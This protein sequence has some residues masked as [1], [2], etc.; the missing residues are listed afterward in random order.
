[1][2]PSKQW[3]FFG[4]SLIIAA[5]VQVIYDH[6]QHLSLFYPYLLGTWWG[7]FIITYELAH[8]LS[9]YINSMA[10]YF[11][12]AYLVIT[13]LTWLALPL[14]AMLFNLIFL[15]FIA[16]LM[17]YYTNAIRLKLHPCLYWLALLAI[18][19]SYPAVFS[20]QRGNIENILFM[21]I[22]VCLI[23]FQRKHYQWS[24]VLLAVA[25][26]MKLYPAVLLILF[27]KEKQY[28]ALLMCVGLTLLFSF[29]ALLSFQGSISANISHYYMNIQQFNEKNILYNLYFMVSLFF[30]VKM[31]LVEALHYSLFF[32]PPATY[33]LPTLFFLYIHK[34]I[35]FYTAAVFSAFIALAFYV[36]YKEPVFWKNVTLLICIMILFPTISHAYKMMH[37]LPA[38]LIFLNRDTFSRHVD[39]VYTCLFVLLF[40]PKI[41]PMI[42][43]LSNIILM[44]TLVLLIIGERFYTSV[45]LR[46]R[47]S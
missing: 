37:L 18:F 45:A 7:D 13:P 23:Q 4:L 14:S 6:A 35:P 2:N 28:K 10:M 5:V 33:E 1:M 17:Q 8:S 9:P 29:L 19:V 31:M 43:A 12:L 32:H 38:F 21:I 47:L 41:T 44:L 30:L 34:I 27:F 42:S 16:W 15:S 22:A 25:I 3:L 26:G 40:I 36:V 24:A 39:K 46:R 20:Y 11:P